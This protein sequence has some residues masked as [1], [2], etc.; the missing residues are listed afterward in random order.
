MFHEYLNGRPLGP[1]LEFWFCCPIPPPFDRKW[2]LKNIQP[3]KTAI[4]QQGRGSRQSN[5]NQMERLSDNRD[6]PHRGHHGWYSFG[7]IGAGFFLGG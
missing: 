6:S 1:L 3:P 4:H 5:T 7:A 2:L